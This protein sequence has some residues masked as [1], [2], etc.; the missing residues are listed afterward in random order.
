ME[1]S[2]K[3]YIP[4]FC[5][6]PARRLPTPPPPLRAEKSHISHVESREVRSAV[7]ISTRIY[8]SRGEMRNGAIR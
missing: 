4:L 3:N 1:K 8:S 5:G 2:S 6:N 7:A